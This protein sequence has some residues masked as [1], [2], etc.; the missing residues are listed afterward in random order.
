M[1]LSL[2]MN[3]CRPLV[4]LDNHTH[5]VSIQDG[6]GLY[7]ID[8]KETTP[9]VANALSISLATCPG[10][11]AAIWS[12]GKEVRFIAST[13]KGDWNSL[14]NTLLWSGNGEQPNLR[15]DENTVTTTWHSDTST[16]KDSDGIVYVKRAYL[17]SG[18]ILSEIGPGKYPSISNDRDVIVFRSKRS[19]IWKLY[20]AT[21]VNDTWIT[22]E[23][24]VEGKD[25]SIAYTSY[26][27][28][29]IAFQ[30]ASS[31]YLMDQ[32]KV[33][34]K[35]A[36]VGLFPSIALNSNNDIIVGYERP[37]S[38]GSISDNKTKKA[39]LLKISNGTLTD[40]TPETVGLSY[41]I[42]S[43]DGKYWSA[44]SIDGTLITKSI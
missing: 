23:T 1:S 15:I 31:I 39:G 7:F 3:G 30:N 8:N 5:L 44:V 40:L 14:S 17:D 12:T 37:A 22:T 33:V 16:N 43:P 24:N 42:V 34:T 9:P 41:T 18:W 29:C 13:G 35:I 19:G 26:N 10:N 38:K 2:A 36:S 32:Y 6:K 4:T 20:T 11:V 21:L 25:P 27:A 28:Q